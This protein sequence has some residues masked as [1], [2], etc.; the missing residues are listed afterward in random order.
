MF[1]SYQAQ[2]AVCL[3]L[4]AILQLNSVRLRLETRAF[5]FQAYGCA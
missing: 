3:Y 4:F 5:E 1:Y 2:E